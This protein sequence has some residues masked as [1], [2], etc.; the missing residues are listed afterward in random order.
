MKITIERRDG[1]HPP[2][3]LGNE[4][5]GTLYIRVGALS[6]WTISPDLAGGLVILEH[7]CRRWYDLQ[8]PGETLAN[9][10]MKHVITH[11]CRE[12]P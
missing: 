2:D 8:L 6:G 5:D 7:R 12:K 10:I 9:A 4:E 1:Q 11:E 3:T